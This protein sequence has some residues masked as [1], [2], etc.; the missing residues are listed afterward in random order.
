MSRSS[1]RTLRSPGSG[2]ASR[3]VRGALL[4]GLLGA[5]GVAL[6]ATVTIDRPSQGSTAAGGTVTVAVSVSSGFQIGQD[7]WVQIWV[8]GRPTKVLAGTNGT[9]TMP[10]GDHEIQARL[11][12]LKHQAL[13]VPANS[14]QITVTVPIPDPHG[15]G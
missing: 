1:A 15:P 14:E 10:P 13:R 11:V 5:A 6:G 8:D 3:A 4:V 2:T 12:N 7:G 9:V